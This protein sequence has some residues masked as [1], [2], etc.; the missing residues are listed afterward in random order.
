MY[1]IFYEF[2][3]VSNKLQYYTLFVYIVN[4]DM[5]FVFQLVFY[6]LVDLHPLFIVH[7]SFNVSFYVIILHCYSTYLLARYLAFSHAGLYR[8]R[9]QQKVETKATGTHATE[10][11]EDGY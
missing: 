2:L 11:G 8:E 7:P 4:I 9:G 5:L 6:V 10:N 1:I 3:D